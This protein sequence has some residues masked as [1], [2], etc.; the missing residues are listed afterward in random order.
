MEI[1]KKRSGIMKKIFTILI[2]PAILYSHICAM[3][4]DKDHGELHYGPTSFTS[5]SNVQDTPYKKKLE[6]ISTHLNNAIP[7][8][9]FF[10]TSPSNLTEK[11]YF[12]LIKI[13]ENNCKEITNPFLIDLMKENKYFKATI[14]YFIN[15]AHINLSNV[16]TSTLNTVIDPAQQQPTAALNK[17]CKVLKE[18]VM[19]YAWGEIKHSYTMRF[20]GHTNKI[21]CLDINQESHRAAS[22]S[23]DG[24][25]KVWDIATCK[26]LY[27]LACNNCRCIK[28]NQNGTL[29]ATTEEN[30][31]FES[32]IKIWHITASKPE[33]PQHIVNHKTEYYI[34]K[35]FFFGKQLA[36]FEENC[37]DQYKLN[38]NGTVTNLGWTQCKCIQDTKIHDSMI[39]KNDWFLTQNSLYLFLCKQ[40]VINTP[41]KDSLFS[42]TKTTPYQ[43]LVP[44]AQDLVKA[45]MKTKRGVTIN[46]SI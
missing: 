19:N 4:F 1:E 40:A 27:T 20:S 2:T 3:D 23:C 39:H 33:S 32:K 44:Y 42:I 5:H 36:V 21:I 24:S 6:T 30:I 7:Q 46:S 16:T 9:I 38:K 26:E 8:G 41:F 34:H 22:I 45:D 28:F 17:L 37:M 35:L 31:R 43:K 29:L 14:D 25:C 11:E 18:Y 13:V 12:N 10:Q 15:L